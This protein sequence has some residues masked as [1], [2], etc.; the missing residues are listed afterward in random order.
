MGMFRSQTYGSIVSLL[1]LRLRP[2][3]ESMTDD[4]E[5]CATHIHRTGRVHSKAQPVRH[6]ERREVLNK[7]TLQGGKKESFSAGT[8][9]G[10][11]LAG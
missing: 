3:W 10:G 2:N 1:F 9:V 4:T 5:R 11:P 6:A 7:Q 8:G